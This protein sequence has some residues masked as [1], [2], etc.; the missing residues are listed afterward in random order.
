MRTPLHG[1]H[2]AENGSG[3]IRIPANNGRYRFEPEV[4]G[5]EGLVILPA[6]YATWWEYGVS[7]LLLLVLLYAAYQLSASRRQDN[8]RSVKRRE[9]ASPGENGGLPGQVVRREPAMR[10]GGQFEE[11]RLP[12]HFEEP[13]SLPPDTDGFYPE[14]KE[15]VEKVQA[16][17]KAHLSNPEFN[18][19][20]LCR[21]LSI[22]RSPLHNKLKA[23]TGCSATRYIRAIR[24]HYAREFLR[25]TTLP[26]SEIAYSVGFKDPNFFSTCFKE[27]F[28]LTPTGFRKKE[29]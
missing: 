1:R 13:E 4:A 16:I 24:L 15:F 28:G 23:L 2:T 11:P 18:L 6:W 29:Q 19:H 7:W 8:A 26:V 10:T 27:E 22:T 12:D 3:S 5:E 25:K 9:K 20:A 21:E 17:I 14:E